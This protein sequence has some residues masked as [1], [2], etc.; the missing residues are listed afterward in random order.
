MPRQI[1]VC[2]FWQPQFCSVSLFLHKQSLR[3]KT[4]EDVHV[5]L[6]FLDKHESLYLHVE[7]TLKS[8]LTALKRAIKN[9]PN[10]LMTNDVVDIEVANWWRKSFP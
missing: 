8:M 6:M 2:V 10:I 1:C 3:E 4:L 5:T 7:T 9:V